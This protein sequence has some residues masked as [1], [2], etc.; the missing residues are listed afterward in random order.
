ML[1]YFFLDQPLSKW[2]DYL[3]KIVNVLN[4]H[5]E[6]VY[7]SNDQMLNAYFTKPVTVIPQTV[8]K[9]YKFNINQKV[10]ID[11]WPSQRRNLSFKYSLNKGKF[12]II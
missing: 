9:M 1:K 8:K 10:R 11:A 5:N 3:P 7:K 2:R 4:M 6:K 12:L